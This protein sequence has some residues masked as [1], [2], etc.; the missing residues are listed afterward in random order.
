MLKRSLMPGK[1]IGE[2][3]VLA[4]TSVPADPVHLFHSQFYNR[5]SVANFP[6]ATAHNSWA[7]HRSPLPNFPSPTHCF[8]KVPNSRRYSL[9][10]QRSLLLVRQVGWWMIFTFSFAPPNIITNQLCGR[11]P[12]IVYFFLWPIPKGSQRSPTYLSII[13]ASKPSIH[14]LRTIVA[15]YATKRG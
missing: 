11:R 6:V 2:V 8:M 9:L 7:W 13:W 10:I 4:S 3:K 5:K 1:Q 14:S 12:T 15:E